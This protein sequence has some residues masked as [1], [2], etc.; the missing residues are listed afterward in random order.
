MN[1]NIENLNLLLKSKKM[2]LFD[3]DGTL[4]DTETLHWQAFN[5]C[6]KKFNVVLKEKNIKKY[7][8]NQETKI[9]KMIQ[10]DFNIIFDEQ[11]FFE[12][13]IKYYL[14]LVKSENLQPFPY[15]FKLLESQNIEFNILS[16]NR[17]QVLEAVLEIW[18][19]RKKFNKI[20]SAATNNIEKEDVI[21]NIEKYFDFNKEDVALFEDSAKYLKIGQ[22]SKITSIGIEH[23][24]NSNTLVDCD[25]VWNTL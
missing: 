23:Y 6:L 2:Y 14:Q 8:G 1:K 15:V 19:L 24:Y 13:R 25:Y 11:E 10:E 21:T 22:K 4:A 7:I 9:Y 12:E 20:I 18:G 5:I 3:F 17:L 16:S